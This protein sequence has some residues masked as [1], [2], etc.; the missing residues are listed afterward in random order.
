M[1]PKD[2]YSFIISCSG[3]EQ[4]FRNNVKIPSGRDY[5]SPSTHG[6][7]DPLLEVMANGAHPDGDLSSAL[8]WGRRLKPRVSLLNMLIQA[9]CSRSRSRILDSEC[10]EC[11]KHIVSVVMVMGYDLLG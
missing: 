9:S 11:V 2:P 5:H 4:T 3:L 8:S 10:P 7:P 1:F 6:Y